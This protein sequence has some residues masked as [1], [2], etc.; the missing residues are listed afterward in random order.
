[1][2]CYSHRGPSI[3]GCKPHFHTAFLLKVV[4]LSGLNKHKELSAQAQLH[5]AADK[6]CAWGKGRQWPL[7]K[8]VSRGQGCRADS[9]GRCKR[10]LKFCTGQS[11]DERASAP[12]RRDMPLAQRT[13][14]EIARSPCQW[15]TNLSRLRYCHIKLRIAFNSSDGG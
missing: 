9:L 2:S 5:Y 13:D 3:V 7:S 11:V 12:K 15:H 6:F 8:R 1:M 4:C 14:T 10:T